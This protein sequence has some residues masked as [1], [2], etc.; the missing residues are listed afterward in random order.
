MTR[1]YAVIATHNRQE[2]CGNL[3]RQLAEQDVTVVVVDN[4]SSPPL[5]Y[6]NFGDADPLIMEK[7]VIEYNDLVGEEFNLS[8]IWNQGLETAEAIH[9][10]QGGGPWVVAVLNDDISIPP[11]FFDKCEQ[12]L[13]K[14]GA[15]TAYPDQDGVL[16]AGPNYLNTAPPSPTVNHALKMTGFAHVTQ[17]HLG[18]RF[19]ERMKV[20]YSD[21]GW[22]MEARRRGGTVQVADL[23]VEHLD[24]NGNFSRNAWWQEQAG[25]DRETFKEIYGFAA[26]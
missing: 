25:R 19:D 9:R 21:N 24:A 14:T 20:W 4:N 1:R 13:E 8:A 22:E 12:A 6:S 11:D 3:V 23:R 7:V 16:G 26:W 2:W 17:G 5:S 10:A 15:A 18:I